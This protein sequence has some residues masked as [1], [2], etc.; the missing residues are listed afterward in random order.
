MDH[1]RL[2]ELGGELELGGEEPPLVVGRRVVAEPVEP[3]LAD[4]DRLRMREQLAQ[5]CEVV[6]GRRARVVRV[7]AEDRE[8]PVVPLGERESPAAVVGVRADGED[9]RDAGLGC[10]PDRLVGVVE[11]GEVRVRVDHGSSAARTSSASSLRKSGRGSR[12]VWPGG[13]S[14]GAQEPTQLA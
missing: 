10:T 4:G 6:L 9:P 14:L 11:R 2:A 1:D 13:S 5:R 8:D 7:D 3:G 12:S